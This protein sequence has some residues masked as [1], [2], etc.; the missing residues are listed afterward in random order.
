MLDLTNISTIKSILRENSLWAKKSFG[1]NFLV[2]EPPLITLIDAA[3]V[4]NQDTVV[5]IGPGLGTLTQELAKKAGLV[6]AIEKDYAM[7]EWLRK[8]F[9]NQKNVKIIHSDILTYD[10]SS[11]ASNYKVIANIPYS[12][13][14]PV[15]RMF[16]EAENK[17]SEMILTIQKEVA[18]R[19]TSKPGDKN[20]GILTVMI[21][22]FCEKAEIV[23]IVDRKNFFPVPDVDSAI[24]KL[25]VRSK[26]KG[27]SNIDEKSFFR[28]V[29]I[30]FSQKRRQI[31][32]PLLAGL[33]LPKNQILSILKSAKIDQQKRAEDLILDDWLRLMEEI[34]NEQ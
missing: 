24:I 13:T 30:G 17:P 2:A 23:E 16:L 6:L 21:E 27:L 15:I 33:R 31:H 5:E 25:A 28:L 29:K 3:N 8:Y 32:N 20:R 18:E 34:K 22:L 26:N 10:L 4:T 9:K 7:I 11:I 1:Q 12:I 14:S 19:L